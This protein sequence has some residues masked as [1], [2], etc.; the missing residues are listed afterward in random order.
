MKKIPAL[1]AAEASL[2]KV[3]AH[4]VRVLLLEVLAESLATAS[5]LREA[6]GIRPS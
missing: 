3:L 4:P 2:F 5:S 1:R 6:A